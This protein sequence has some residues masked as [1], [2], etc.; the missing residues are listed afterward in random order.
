MPKKN[1]QK[2][3]KRCGFAVIVGAPNT[4]KSTLTNALIGAK[5]SIVSPKAQTTRS[6]ITGI[7][8]SGDTQI[9]LVDTP[10]IFELRGNLN[11][12]FNKAIVD[13]AKNSI[14]G[15]DFIFYMIDSSKGLRKNDNEAL[16]YLSQFKTPKILIL[17][18]ID[19]ISKPKLLDLTQEL[20]AKAEF[21]KTFMISAS[22]KDGV[23][24]IENFLRDNLPKSNWLYPEDEISTA[25]AKFLASEITREKL[26]INL[27]EELPYSLIVET[28]KFEERDNDIKIHQTI[29]TSSDMHKRMI[30]G[31]QG[32]MIK[33]IGQQSR[34]ELEKLFE[35]KIHLFLFVKVRENLFDRKESYMIS[36]IDM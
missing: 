5:V 9:I 19:L 2:S 1:L 18:K 4:G 22:K 21:A 34:R 11:N 33:K 32:A 17:N 3:E 15:C 36:N 8:I 7:T 35:K 16:Q 28:E 29:H 24:Q 25:P 6:R 30:V 26:F 12:K 13:T 27:D 10:G 31:R 14:E 23:E 20:N